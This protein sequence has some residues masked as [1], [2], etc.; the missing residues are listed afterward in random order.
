M[1]SSQ[2][3]LHTG[4]LTNGLNHQDG[5][6]FYSNTTEQSFMTPVS[7]R[8]INKEPSLFQS[9]IRKNTNKESDNSS[10][11][12]RRNNE[13]EVINYLPDLKLS[14]IIEDPKIKKRLLQSIMQ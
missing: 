11:I 7:G 10:P 8:K 4:F 13:V 1:S 6:S 3:N 5:G 12:Q 14:E 2:P 9:I